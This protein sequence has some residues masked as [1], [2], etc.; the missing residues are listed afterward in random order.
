MKLFLDYFF[1]LSPLTLHINAGTGRNNT[2]V[3]LYH[4][5]F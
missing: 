3:K 4:V 1:D 5:K 2:V